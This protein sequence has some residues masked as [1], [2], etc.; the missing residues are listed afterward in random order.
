MAQLPV[1]LNATVS[2][3]EVM[4]G[5]LG[6]KQS[7]EV[8]GLVTEKKEGLV[9]SDFC[10]Y[11]EIDGM[12]LLIYPKSVVEKVARTLETGEDEKKMVES[13]GEFLNI[14]SSKSRIKMIKNGIDVDMTLPRSFETLESAQRIVGT[15]SGVLATFRFFDDL[16]YI[17]LTR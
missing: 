16:F 2:T 9:A 6:Q 7:V 14:V 8:S 10:F 17:F 15:R 4:T 12:L 1:F 3:L 11:G 13:F 5:S